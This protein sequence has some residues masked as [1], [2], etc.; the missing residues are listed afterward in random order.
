MGAAE[1]VG[2]SLELEEMCAR[3][4]KK[5]QRFAVESTPFADMETYAID[6]G[7]VVTNLD[8]IGIYLPFHAANQE[9]GHEEADERKRALGV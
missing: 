2:Q 4:M 6:V 8:F 9:H 7:V 1:P 5:Q 3:P